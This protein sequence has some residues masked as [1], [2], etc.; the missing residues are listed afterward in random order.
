MKN[1]LLLALKTIYDKKGEN[2]LIIE[3]GKIIPYLTDY[4]VIATGYTGDHL[5]A[6]ADEVEEKLGEE[7]IFPDHIEGYEVGRWILMDYIDFVIH[8][9][10]GEA[11]EYYGLE[12]LWGD[13][14]TYKYPEDFVHDVEKETGGITEKEDI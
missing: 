5:R 9:M 13:A 14:P 3:V 8:I 6:I 2:I 4:F 10:V 1:S 12:Y 11:R 7:G